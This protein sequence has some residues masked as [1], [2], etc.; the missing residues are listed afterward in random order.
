MDPT[1]VKG[2]VPPAAMLRSPAELLADRLVGQTI[3]GRFEVKSLLGSGAM[4]AVCRA[5]QTSVGRD[6]A[7]KVLLADGARL[8]LAH[9]FMLEARTT[10]ALRNVHTVTLFDFG[11]SDDGTLY[12][13]MELL[14][15]EDLSARIKRA[16]PLEWR[17]ALRVVGQVA[18]SLAEAHGKNIIHRDL[19]PANIFLTKMGEDEAFVKVL[20][21][22]IAKLQDGLAANLTGTG[23]IIGTPTY[24]SPEQALGEPFDHRAD[25][26]ALGVVLYHALA[27][28]PPFA[29]DNPMTVL[30][31]HCQKEAPPLD[32]DIPA[33]VQRLVDELLEK[34]PSKRID[35]AA[36]LR[37]RV[38]IIL[39]E[40][41]SEVELPAELLSQSGSWR[42]SPL[43]G[44]EP[45]LSALFAA[46]ETTRRLGAQLI[47]P[48]VGDT[49]MGKS[50]LLAEFGQ[51]LGDR[52]LD[53]W[54]WVSAHCTSSEGLVGLEP[55][56]SSLKQAPIS[57]DDEDEEIGFGADQLEHQRTVFSPM[58]RF[59]EEAL[60]D[61]VTQQSEA[62]AAGRA[63]AIVRWVDSVR[64]R[65]RHRPMILIVEDLQWAKPEA[66]A[67][68]REALKQ[69]RDLPM[70]VV[71]TVRVLEASAVFRAL[72]LPAHR[73]HAVH[74]FALRPE[75]V[76][77][78]VRSLTGDEVEPSALTS[79]QAVAE[80]VPRRVIE[81]VDA[82]FDA[83]PPPLPVAAA[84][85]RS[86]KR[87]AQETAG[88]EARFDEARAAE[89]TRIDT[90]ATELL[91]KLERLTAADRELLMAMVVAGETWTL[92]LLEATLGREVPP[93][94]IERLRRA[95][96]EIV[97]RGRHP[98]GE[99]G[100]G[101][102]SE[103][104]RGIVQ[105]ALTPE[106]V[107][108]MHARAAAWL[109]RRDDR[110]KRS[111]K[112]LIQQHI[113]GAQGPTRVA[114]ALVRAGRAARAAYD[115]EV[116]WSHFETALELFP[117][118]PGEGAPEA[119]L[120][121]ARATAGWCECALGAG[122][123]D[124]AL[125][126]SGQ[127]LS[128][129]E[130]SELGEPADRARLL[131]VRAVALD[132]VERVEEAL[133][134]YTRAARFGQ[135][136]GGIG[137]YAMGQSARAM[138]DVR[139]IG[140]ARTIAKLAHTAAV[141]LPESELGFE[142]HRGLGAAWQ[143]LG[144]LD[145]RAR[146]LTHAADQ[147]QR[148]VDAYLDGGDTAGAAQAGRCNEMVRKL[149]KAEALERG[150]KVDKAVGLASEVLGASKAMEYPEGQVLATVALARGLSVLER[151]DQALARLAEAEADALEWGL[152]ELVPA[153]LVL[154]A[155]ICLEMSDLQSAS[156][157]ADKA[158]GWASRLGLST[159]AEA[160]AEL[161]AQVRRLEVGGQASPSASSDDQPGLGSSGRSQP[162][163]RG[164][165]AALRGKTRG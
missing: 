59:S 33:S 42:R 16:G 120:A 113:T 116:A 58:P 48:L 108:P 107:A 22:G 73:C 122:R 153:A 130:A 78:L 83:P 81:S 35:S 91:R 3:D 128:R 133:D 146:D 93:L 55:L 165:A 145:C 76:Q 88:E 39:E 138:M 10:S 71:L 104:M 41:T 155:Q 32:I 132:T 69:A 140:D 139:R 82:L 27:G 131:M 148:A 95:G 12:L 125:E 161:L 57:S 7:L 158:N 23:A 34:D 26:Y 46:A 154:R 157:A 94:E 25:M 142:Y 89:V 8:D 117:E 135:D 119:L 151:F 115:D 9:R 127:A 68:L 162:A 44:R 30:L 67:V 87:V 28:H 4:G 70:L 51:R 47:V 164:W 77:S 159:E 20:D 15:G 150:G 2:R 97:A 109:L 31:M 54:A 75:E 134:C 74:L 5:T 141:G 80:G 40:G 103:L 37:K 112:A 160:S 52:G 65:T 18:E 63:E 99:L 66:L 111:V 85:P 92:P 98:T 11:Q 62:G 102:E 36:T 106:L 101:F 6:V 137:I 110:G 100:R 124:E 45:E 118:P 72:E 49:G 17:D 136:A 152:D 21:F 126:R 147:Y 14:E 53:D 43:I 129:L 96:F 156:A 38:H 105:G 19:K 121:W 90:S 114:A 143:T 163:T 13:A 1:K 144:D 60:S 64:D 84:R 50:R 79:I 149:V 29:H 86:G 24:M 56:A 61:L 123:L